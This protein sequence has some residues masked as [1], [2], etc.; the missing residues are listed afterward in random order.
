MQV[1][2]IAIGAAFCAV[3][4]DWAT[5]RSAGRELPAGA[6]RRGR[7]RFARRA[8]GGNGLRA[9]S[10]RRP[11]RPRRTRRDE[12]STGKASGACRGYGMRGPSSRAG[13][14]RRPGRRRTCPS[15]PGRTRHGMPGGGGPV[16]ANV[17]PL[18]GAHKREGIRNAYKTEVYNF[19]SPENRLDLA[20]RRT[21]IAHS[22]GSGRSQEPVA[23]R[24]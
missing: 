22:A 12:R 4:G 1:L 20:A 9:C 7:R 8:G 10:S 19:T 15:P 6:R 21:R 13:R 18:R 3:G 2:V 23:S 14:A 24:R 5:D 16:K 11:R 17:T